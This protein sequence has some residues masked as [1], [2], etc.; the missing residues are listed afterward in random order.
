MNVL[1]LGLVLLSMKLSTIFMHW[2]CYAHRGRTSY[3]VNF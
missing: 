1:H 3:R 2:Y